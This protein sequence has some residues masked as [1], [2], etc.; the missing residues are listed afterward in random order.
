MSEHVSIVEERG[1]TPLQELRFQSA[2]DDSPFALGGRTKIFYAHHSNFRQGQVLRVA[3]NRNILN[4]ETDIAESVEEI[5]IM[6]E[7]P[8]MQSA[9]QAM[10]YL[11]MLENGSSGLALPG[12][13]QDAKNPQ[14]QDFRNNLMALI[15]NAEQDRPE[16]VADFKKQVF[17][18]MKI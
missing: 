3:V 4:A 1:D 15:A 10:V 8:K 14:V 5:P 7:R 17:P 12:S 13:L 11:R 2:Y 9:L 18:E 6:T 16:I